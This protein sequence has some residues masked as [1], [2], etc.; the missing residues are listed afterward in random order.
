M[1]STHQELHK[2]SIA[3]EVQ[4]I[5]KIWKEDGVWN[6]SAYDLP[7]VSFD[8][9]LK[10]AQRSFVEAL[11]GHFEVLEEL[12]LLDET[13]RHLKEVQQ[14]R[15]FWTERMKPMQTVQRFAWPAATSSELCAP[16]TC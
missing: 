7:V 2:D 15:D 1:N 11:N 4:I 5:A 10:V 9:T 3:L 8:K 6:V 14:S 12:N 16:T 13:V